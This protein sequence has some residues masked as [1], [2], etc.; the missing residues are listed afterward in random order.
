MGIG[1]KSQNKEKIAAALLQCT[2]TLRLESFG[3]PETGKNYGSNFF[4]FLIF[5]PNV[6]GHTVTGGSGNDIV[7]ACIRLDF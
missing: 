4:F 6:R 3:V 5:F 7:D 1:K 2:C